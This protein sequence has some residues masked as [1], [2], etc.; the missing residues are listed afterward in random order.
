MLCNINTLCH[1][2][3]SCT[4][5]LGLKDGR[6]W[7]F[8]VQVADFTINLQDYLI[9][10]KNYD[11]FQTLHFDWGI[12]PSSKE[13]SKYILKGNNNVSLS[14]ICHMLFFMKKN[15]KTQ[16]LN[17]LFNKSD[18]FLRGGVSPLAPPRF[19]LSRKNFQD[20]VGFAVGRTDKCCFF[21]WLLW[22]M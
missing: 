17:K 16:W 19:I 10:I 12:N 6:G 9:G 13:I 21:I 14:Y 7:G 18:E 11:P 1:C 20:K 4:I 2:I 3:F 8:Q 22:C 5:I 15:A